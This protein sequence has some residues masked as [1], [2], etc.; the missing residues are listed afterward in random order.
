[1]IDILLFFLALCE[2]KKRAQMVKDRRERLVLTVPIKS[3][4]LGLGKTYLK[5]TEHAA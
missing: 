1:M 5:Q 3:G 2:L 4:V